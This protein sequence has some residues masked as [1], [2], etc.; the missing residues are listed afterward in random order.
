MET[1]KKIWNFLNSKLFIAL[2][3]I[4]LIMMV[5]RQCSKIDD[6]KHQ[7]NLTNQNIIALKDSLKHEK[8]KS[9][10]L[11]VSIAGY[12]SSEKEL[13]SLNKD[14]WEKVQQQK[15]TILSLNTA[16]I[17][18]VQD[19]AILRKYLSEK[20]SIIQQ[21]LCIDE[22]TFSAQ[23]TLTYRYDTLNFDSFTGK[24]YIGI[25]SKDPLILSHINTEMIERKTQIDLT[26]GQ[27]ME[28][29]MLRVFVTSSYP[30]F[31]VSQMQGVLIDPEK[32]PEMFN[33]KKHWFTGFSIGVGTTGGFNVTTGKYGLVIGPSFMWNIYTW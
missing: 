21:L 11:E 25:I 10:D 13:K 24:T 26:W 1:I 31:N 27:K 2:I 18:L 5:A 15:G 7:K 9:G 12:V 14:L 28:N 20:E 8:T 19:T 29:D 32:Y 6:L 33:K 30:G 16:L 17:T 3:I 23:W 4:G 22:N